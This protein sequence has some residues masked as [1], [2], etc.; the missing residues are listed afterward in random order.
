MRAV[1]LDT[2]GLLALWDTSDQW[3]AP[4]DAAYQLLNAGPVR[5]VA[6]TLV[7]A[8]CGNA[9]A[10]RPYRDDP[11]DLWAALDAAG[12]LLRPTDAQLDRAWDA[13]RRRLHAAAGFVDQ[14][15]FVLMADLGVREAFTNDAHFRAAGFVTLF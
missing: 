2:V 12:D 4:A 10:R 7:L 3:H 9:A 5:L 11:A 14:V 6:S 15:S 8:E 1:F 13:Y